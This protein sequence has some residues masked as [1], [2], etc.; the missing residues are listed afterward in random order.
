MMAADVSTAPGKPVAEAGG[1]SLVASRK[2]PSPPAQP[3]MLTQTRAT[4][5]KTRR[6]A[7]PLRPAFLFL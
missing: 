3:D 4:D 2:R 7:Y 6:A 1:L 5:K